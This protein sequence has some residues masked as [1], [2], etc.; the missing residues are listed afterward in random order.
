L[1]VPDCK[2]CPKCGEEVT[3]EFPIRTV[4][5]LHGDKADTYN[6]GL[7]LGLSKEAAENFKYCTYEIGVEVEVYEDGQYKILGL[8]K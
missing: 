8:K 4:V 7:E 6:D 1:K 3:L 2:F 5:Y